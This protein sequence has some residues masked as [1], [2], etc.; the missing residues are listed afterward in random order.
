ME[1]PTIQELSRLP[2]EEAVSRRFHA[3]NYRGL[4]LLA[5]SGAILG[6]LSLLYHLLQGNY[7]G[8]IAPV[9][10]LALAQWILTGSDRSYFQKRLGWIVPVSIVSFLALIAWLSPT[11]D[12]GL[13]IVGIVGVMI[14]AVG[15]RLTPTVYVV[16]FS[17]IWLLTLAPPIFETIRDQLP[18]PTWRIT[19]QSLATIIGLYFAISGTR[20]ERMSFE[21][22]H[23]VEASRTRERTRMREELASARQ[24]Q[25]SMLPRG[26]PTVAGLDLASVSLPA[27]EVGG[28]Y[29]EYFE[30]P[31]G[32]LDLAIGDVA[33]HGLA[34]GLML[35]GLRS[36][37]HLLQP[38]EPPPVEIMN[39][40]HRMVRRTTDQRLFITLL[41]AQIDPTA[42]EIRLAT[43]GHPPLLHLSSGKITELGESALPLG[44]GLVSTYREVKVSYRP[45]DIFVAYTDGLTE[46]NNRDD[47][48]YGVDRLSRCLERLKRRETAR[49]IREAL[50][51]DVW[52]FKGDV[53]Q[54]DDITMVVMRAVEDSV[55]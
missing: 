32:H 5:I 31:G 23:K 42:R 21:R 49:E 27:T 24:I 6:F 28:D 2:V 52:N 11:P 15:Y 35:S 51:A 54:N 18:P 10:L 8:L 50:L 12:L 34:S 41:F 53:E 36:C 7:R 19:V 48:L 14:L 17:L 29:Y 1:I 26:D 4:R 44:T 33:G 55:S 22:Q 38:D 39:R 30:H 20:R 46:T 47:E 13:R 37:L 45:G 25:L 3:H 16:L 43:A 9:I 40:L